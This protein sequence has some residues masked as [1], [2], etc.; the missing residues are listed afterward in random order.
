LPFY[1]SK[2]HVRIEKAERLLGYRPEF[3]FDR[4]MSLTEKWARWAN[5]FPDGS[6]I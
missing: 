4:G 1:A 5:L 3:D 6:A 2:T